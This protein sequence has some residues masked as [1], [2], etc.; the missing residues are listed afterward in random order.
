MPIFLSIQIIDLRSA[1]WNVD[2]YFNG[3]V[4]DAVDDDDDDNGEIAEETVL[5]IFMTGREK[6]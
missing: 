1:H 2:D 6:P 4:D 5:D 3:A